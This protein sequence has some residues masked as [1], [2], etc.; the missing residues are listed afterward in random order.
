M[1]FFK[2]YEKISSIFKRWS[3]SFFFVDY[4]NIREK[5]FAAKKKRVL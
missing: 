4:K 1:M 3:K 5:K 2:L